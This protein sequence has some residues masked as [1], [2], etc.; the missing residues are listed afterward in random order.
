MYDLMANDEKHLLLN[1][2]DYIWT[3]NLFNDLI[4]K[5]S[6][7]ERLTPTPQ[8]SFYYIYKDFFLKQKQS[9][10]L[11]NYWKKKLFMFPNAIILG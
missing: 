3:R 8:L 1:V 11:N 2:Y 4:E 6:S 7:D 9:G 10:N 5:F